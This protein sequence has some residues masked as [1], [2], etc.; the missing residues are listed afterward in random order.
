MY[1]SFRVAE[2]IGCSVEE[3]DNRLANEEFVQWIA[4]L[5]KKDERF[6]KW[7]WY[8]AQIAYMVAASSGAKGIKLKD[9]TIQSQAP[10]RVKPMALLHTIAQAFGAKV[11]KHVN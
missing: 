11:E 4:Y 1:C 10:R 6:E 8:A 9:F 7:E 5:K 3:L 2:I